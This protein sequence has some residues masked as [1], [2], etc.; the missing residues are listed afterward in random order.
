MELTNEGTAQTIDEYSRSSKK[1]IEP[2]KQRIS[3]KSLVESRPSVFN[4]QNPTAEISKYP[5]IVSYSTESANIVQDQYHH[6]P[7][8]DQFKII[9]NIPS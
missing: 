1:T 2:K 9:E 8:L 6:T 4:I 3:V 5:D 7:T